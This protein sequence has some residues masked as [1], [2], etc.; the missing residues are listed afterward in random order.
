MG[1]G[2]AYPYEHFL[3]IEEDDFQIHDDD[4]NVI[5]FDEMAFTDFQEQAAKCFKAELLKKEDY[6]NRRESYIFA[7]HDK[8]NMGIDYSGGS[9]CIFL[10]PKEYEKGD[11]FYEYKIDR[12]AVP[13]FNKLINLYG[14]TLTKATSPWTSETI[15]H[16]ETR[17]QNH[18]RCTYQSN[19]NRC[20][21]SAKRNQECQ[22]NRGFCNY[23]RDCNYCKNQKSGTDA[24]QKN[25][26]NFCKKCS[27]RKEQ[28]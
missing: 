2:I 19:L 12:F 15:Q 3:I 27:N 7:E 21:H 17:K 10:E 9:P 11:Y 18:F 4:N 14:Q 13:G 20:N 16:Y 26:T 23:F 28:E 8:F 5:D 25:G 22:S 24:F 1:R 6:S